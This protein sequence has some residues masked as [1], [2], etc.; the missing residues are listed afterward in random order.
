MIKPSGPL[1]VEHRLIENMVA[2]LKRE[3]AR[4]R[5]EDKLDL[6]FI[7]SAVDFFRTYADKTHHGKEE[8]ILFRRM[9]KKLMSPELESMRKDLVR[10]HVLARAKVSSLA[11]CRKKYPD[12]AVIKEVIDIM[13]FLIELYPPHIQKEDIVFFP[14]AMKLFTEEE[15]EAM[16]KEFYESDRK[17]IHTKYRLVIDELSNTLSLYNDEETE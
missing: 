3:A 15:L 11:G 13:D 16:T 1:M 7:D 4:I 14:K 8:D 12:S 5:K 2:L 9:D 6:Q 17:M 10:D